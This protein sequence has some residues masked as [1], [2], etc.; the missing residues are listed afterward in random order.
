[1]WNLSTNRI[2]IWSPPNPDPNPDPD[3][4]SWSNDNAN[5]HLL[6]A[7]LKH[8]PTPEGAWFIASDIIE[9]SEHH[10]G[11]AKLAEFYTTA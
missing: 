11:L 5:I 2:Y 7:L 9:A 3:Q 6:K 1:L 8:A 4:H 10:N